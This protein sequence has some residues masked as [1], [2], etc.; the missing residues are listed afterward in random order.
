MAAATGGAGGGNGGAGRKGLEAWEHRHDFEN[1]YDFVEEGSELLI[2]GKTRAERGAVI[3]R[4]AKKHHSNADGT[5]KREFLNM[6]AYTDCYN[7][8]ETKH[9]EYTVRAAHQ[10]EMERHRGIIRSMMRE[11]DL[12]RGYFRAQAQAHGSLIHQQCLALGLPFLQE[13]QNWIE[14]VLEQPPSL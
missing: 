3:L 13:I 9:Q 5:F 12:T 8:L 2:R 7:Y 4:F 14:P 1:D 6:M 11:S 10:S